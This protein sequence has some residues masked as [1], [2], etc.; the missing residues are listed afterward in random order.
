MH[1]GRLGEYETFFK[2]IN[3]PFKILVFTETW[4]KED[5]KDL[6]KFQGFSSVHL[7][8]PTD[9][10]IDFKERGEESQFSYI[11]PLNTNIE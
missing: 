1:D 9:N 3:N 11:T 8:R 2:A 5:K 7:L 4:L 10:H 6:C